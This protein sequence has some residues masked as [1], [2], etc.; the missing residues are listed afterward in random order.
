MLLK[1]EEYEKQ[2][3]DLSYSQLLK[4]RDELIEEIRAYENH[5]DLNT[6]DYDIEVSPDEVYQ[7]NL[8]YLS[9]ICRLMARKVLESTSSLHIIRPEDYQ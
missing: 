6:Y 9:E 3:E 4:L 7:V 1:P 5:S 2:H 8:L